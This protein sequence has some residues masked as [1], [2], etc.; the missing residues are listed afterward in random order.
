M[1]WSTELDRRGHEVTTFASGD[2][3]VP[4][5]HVE[6]VPEALRPGRLHRRLAAVHA[7]DASTRSSR[8]SH[9]FD[10]IHSHLEWLSLL[11]ARGHERAGRDD[12]PRP[13]R[14]ALGRRPVPRPAARPRRHQPEPGRH[15][16]GRPLGRRSST[17]ACGSIERAVRQAPGRALC[18][19]G[20]V[21]QEKGI[22]EAIEI[23]QLA[24]RPLQ[25]AAKVA[26]GGPERE[27]YDA[28]FQPALKAAGSSVEYLGELRA[29]RPRPA[30]R[31]ELRLADAGLV[32]RAVRARRDRGAGLRHAGHR[33]AHRRV[34][35]DHP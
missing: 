23:A 9:E 24:G 7:T 8:G 1:A 27:Y 13:A 4:G 12:V 33:P 35:R 34:A 5:R 16:S 31:R 3:V 30:V 19:V 11:L 15:A 17:T 28:V 22:V 18:F 26:P 6:T 20:R 21:A 10:L 29:G 32:A 14:P 2:S 25:I